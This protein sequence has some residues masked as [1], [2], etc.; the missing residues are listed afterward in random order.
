[1]PYC[2]V[3]CCLPHITVTRVC[4]G[5]E[6]VGS[7][8]WGARRR[9]PSSF[10]FGESLSCANHPRPAGIRHL[11]VRMIPELASVL[12]RNLLVLDGYSDCEAA[13]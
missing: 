11:S 9:Y 8:A 10:L 6:S 5:S 7:E 4:L 13:A 1:M 2:S 12:H 3:N